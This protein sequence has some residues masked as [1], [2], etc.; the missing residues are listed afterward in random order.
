MTNPAPDLAAVSCAFSQALPASVEMPAGT[1]KTQLLAATVTALTLAGSTV[2]VLTH[3]HAGVDAIRR[4]LK[5][6]H[7]PPLFTVTTITSFAFRLARAYPTLAGVTVPAVPAWNDSEAYLQGAVNTCSSRHIR[8]VLE[9][10]FAVLLVDEYQDNSQLQ[11]E[12]VVALS[13]AIRRIGVLGD[14]LQAIFGFS[15]PLV[16]WPTV[17]DT[18]PP[19]QASIK[20]WRWHEHNSAL[21]EWLLAIRPLL[22]AGAT[23]DLSPQSLPPGVTFVA[24]QHARRSMQ[25]RD[26]VKRIPRTDSAVVISGPRPDQARRMSADLT[27]EYTTMEDIAGN[28]MNERLTRL[29]ATPPEQYSLWLAE[30]IKKCFS[31]HS[32]I[33]RPIM[34]KLRHGKDIRHLRRDGLADAVGALATLT[35]NPSLHELAAAM[36]DIRNHPGCLRLHSR[37]AWADMRTAILESAAA[38]DGSVDLVDALARTRDRL[39]HMGRGNRRRVVSR[40]LLVKGLE[41]DH[42]ILADVS[43]ISDAHNLYVALSRGRKTVTI[44]GENDHITVTPTQLAPR[45]SAR[46]SARAKNGRG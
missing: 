22:T 21:G 17:T 44:L 38:E 6:F 10:S 7:A 11:H 9:A 8:R 1:G 31:G 39:R 4:R 36:D 40:T 45:P 13:R 41:Y 5:H 14:P 25:L 46:G 29:A 35:T 27:G 30:T 2:L 16:P 34:D 3:T 43:A 12:F 37:E 33:D 20:P 28:F 23:L 15:D 32:G 19:F 42:A 26:A 24:T 18:F